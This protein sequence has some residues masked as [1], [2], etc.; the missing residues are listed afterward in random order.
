MLTELTSISSPFAN[1]PKFARPDTVVPGKTYT[2]MDKR[3]LIRVA[4]TVAVCA[5]PPG[6][7]GFV[8]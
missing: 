5:P 6:R 7:S 4:I 1:S 3:F 8:A 2:V